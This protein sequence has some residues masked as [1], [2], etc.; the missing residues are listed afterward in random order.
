MGESVFVF[1]GARVRV[2][3]KRARDVSIDLGVWVRA[4]VVAL[5]PRKPRCGYGVQAGTW[6]TF[7]YG[8]MGDTFQVA[9]AGGGGVIGSKEAVLGSYRPR[10]R[11]AN[12]TSQRPSSSSRRPTV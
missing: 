5:A 11:L 6:V 2:R 9:A 7:W 8:Y 10:S 1:E 3:G 4:T 12:V